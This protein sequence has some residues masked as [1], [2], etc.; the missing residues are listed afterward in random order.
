VNVK[1]VATKAVTVVCHNNVEYRPDKSG[2]FEVD[3]RHVEALRPHGLILLSEAGRGA[4][5]TT[6]ETIEVLTKE[7]QE[8]KEKLK[9]VDAG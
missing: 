4:P 6:R 8:L 5:R 7:N 3:E 9:L 2:H 1:M